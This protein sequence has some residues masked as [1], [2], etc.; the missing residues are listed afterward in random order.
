VPESIS[1]ALFTCIWSCYTLVKDIEKERKRAQKQSSEFLFIWASYCHNT[2]RDSFFLLLSFFIWCDADIS[3]W[4]VIII[5]IF[6]IIE[7][8]MAVLVPLSSIVIQYWFSIFY[9][10]W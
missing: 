4:E 8:G 1:H 10:N 6:I 3:L 7:V 9:S 2:W 5:H